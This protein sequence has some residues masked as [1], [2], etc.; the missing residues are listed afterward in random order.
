MH[1]VH[2]LWTGGLDSTCRVIELSRMEGITIQPYYLLDPRRH[3]T[4]QEI[5]AISRI[6]EDIRQHPGGGFC[7]R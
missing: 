2:I 6:F 3:S 7:V 4:R 1:T 5:R